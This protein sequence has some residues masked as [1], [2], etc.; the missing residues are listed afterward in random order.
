MK[1]LITAGPT[2]EFLDPVRFLSNPSSGKMGFA[3]AAAASKHGHEVFL[4]SGP[5]SLPTPPGVKRENVVTAC[6][7]EKAVFSHLEDIEVIIM[8]AAV[9]DYRPDHYSVSKIKKTRD[10]ISLKLVRNPD[11]L[12]KLGEKKNY[13]LV[14]FAAETE[15]V[16]E[17]AK[18]KLLLKNLDLIVTNQIN[19]DGAGFEGDTNSVAVI[20]SFGEVVHIPLSTKQEI[21]EKIIGIIEKE[22]R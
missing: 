12:K 16:I 8:V 10:E 1:F 3:L 5:V 13:F 19:R 9:A 18:K 4:V 14:G 11:I 7:M 6:D 20:S 22:T 2:R 21:A 17:N 15:N